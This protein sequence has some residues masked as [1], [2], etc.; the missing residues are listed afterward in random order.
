MIVNCKGSAFEIAYLN[1][2]DYLRLHEEILANLIVNG[3][4]SALETGC[5][6]PTQAFAIICDYTKKSLRT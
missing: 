6:Y 3:K 2:C 4:S 5:D 1:I